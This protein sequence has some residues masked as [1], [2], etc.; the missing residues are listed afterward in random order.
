MGVGRARCGET[1]RGGA[2][3][4]VAGAGVQVVGVAAEA[5]VG[6]EEVLAG[7]LRASLAARLRPPPPLGGR[8]LL[9]MSGE[10][11]AVIVVAVAVVGVAAAERDGETEAGGDVT[12]DAAGVVALGV[13]NGRPEVKLR[14]MRN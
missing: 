2:E 11:F 9:K 5:V 8:G 14:K 1:E 7:G 13:G 3:V 4:P 12:V 10:L 6:V